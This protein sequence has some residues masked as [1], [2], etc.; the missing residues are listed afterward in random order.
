M[1]TVQV[2]NQYTSIQEA[3]TLQPI[4]SIS[5][6]NEVFKEEAITFFLIKGGS[7]GPTVWIQAAL[8]GDEYDGIVAILQLLGQIDVQALRG[9]II[10][11]PVVNPTA[12]SAGLNGSPKDNIN[13]NRIFGSAQQQSYS[14]QYGHWLMK[15]IVLFATFFID[16]H[17]GGKYLDVCHFAMVAR[18]L[19]EP[20]QQVLTA[21]RHVPLQAIYEC[22][23]N[24][25]G[26]FINEVCSHGIPAVL[27]ESGGGISTTSK[28]VRQHEQAIQGILHHLEMLPTL[29]QLIADTS[30]IT[31]TF[32]TTPHH[33][34][35]IV[36]MNFDVAGIQ[37]Y[38]APAGSMVNK[39]DVLLEVMSIP[40]YTLQQITSPSDH[41]I[42]LSIHSASLVHSGD[43]AVM[44]GMI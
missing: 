27:L 9:N 43:Y 3:L 40:D 6:I 1:F 32:I 18:Q 44:L 4:H 8:H 17:G 31:D 33:I 23:T 20:F 26:M 30:I 21:L 24:A 35:E 37:L 12:F 15:Q 5:K 28:D 11:C 41:A 29:S 10:I 39:G 36:E 2:S 34:T 14:Y 25:K 13:L 19:E 7:D 42:V 22:N 16:L 38:Q